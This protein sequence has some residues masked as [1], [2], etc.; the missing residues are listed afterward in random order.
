MDAVQGYA[1]YITVK[2]E[3]IITTYIPHI[4]EPALRNLIPLIHRIV[5]VLR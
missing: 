3:T 2:K 5:Q 1:F 4:F